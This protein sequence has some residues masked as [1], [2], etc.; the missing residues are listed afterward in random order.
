MTSDLRQHD[1]HSLLVIPENRLAVAAIGKLSPHGKKVAPLVTLVAATGLGKSKLVRELLR[2]WQGPNGKK[3]YLTAS[4]LA[5][6]VAE[7]STGNALAQFQDRLR[8]EV[9]LFVC[10]DIQS[11]GPRKETQQQLIA[12]IDDVLSHQGR[13]LLTSTKMPGEI[14]GLA[15]RLRNRVHGGLCVDIAAP[16]KESRLKLLKHF[17]RSESLS[18]SADGMEAIA[19]TEE[20][21]P[22]DLL[23]VLTQLRAYARTGR[24]GITHER[25]QQ[26]IAEMTT[27]SPLSLSEIARATAKVYQVKVADLKSPQRTQTIATARQAAM[28]LARSTGNLNFVE[29]GEYF[30]RRNHSTVIH[31]CQRI[32]ELIDQDPKVARDIDLIRRRLA[33]FA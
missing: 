27:K 26:V 20:F 21:T 7:A 24:S 11:L 25:I 6:Q 19:A 16:E 12:A 22:R 13:V 29:I 30:N 17:L 28:Y 32:A 15:K 33:S 5:A 31:A 18:L 3:V 1:P 8:K 9:Q 23:A 10:E 4:E 2:K 14:K